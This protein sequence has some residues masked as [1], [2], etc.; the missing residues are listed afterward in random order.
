MNRRNGMERDL[1]TSY[2]WVDREGCYGENY[3]EK[4]LYKQK[5]PG[6]ITFYEIEENDEAR[7]IYRLDGRQSWSEMMKGRR[8]NCG[9]MED[10]IKALTGVME[11]VDE[12]L[13]NPAN[14]I[15][16]MAYIFVNDRTWDFVYVP[17]YEEDFWPQMEKL[18]EE[19][20]NQVDYGDE[21]AVL[22]AYTFYEKV[23]GS[24]CSIEELKKIIYTEAR[25]EGEAELPAEKIEK[26]PEAVNPG[27]T[28]TEKLGHLWSETV[29]KLFKKRPEDG[30]KDYFSEMQ[31]LERTCP[32]LN[33]F[34]EADIYLRPGKEQVLLLI[35]VGENETSVIRIER[36]PFLLGRS[37]E[38]A[39]HCLMFPQI[40]RIHARIEGKDR[41]IQIADM[42]SAN[43]TFRNNERLKPGKEYALHTGDILKLADL[44]FICQL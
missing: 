16:E 30:K 23:H 42:S 27:R 38:E 39:D 33:I 26:K 40:S 29:H 35:P 36:F 22:W 2:L 44:E 10:F 20:L 31:D 4:V 19:W 1:K 17:G 5:V 32:V 18:G 12:Y 24:H 25:K 15:M 6:L 7:L 11:T 13:L 14:L 9:H 21:K 8:M 34:G 28:W 37:L 41:S 3:E 43:G